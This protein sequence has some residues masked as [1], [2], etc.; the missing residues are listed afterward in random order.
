MGLE[1]HFRRVL[2]RRVY[3]VAAPNDIWHIDGYHRLIRCRIIIHEGIDGYSRLI[4]FLK[5]ATNNRADTMLHSFQGV[6]EF[7]LPCRVQMDK[8][9][10]NMLVAQYMLE[11][12]HRGVGQGSAI[13]GRSIHNQRIE[14]L[15]KDLFSGCISYFY[16]FFYFLEDCGLLQINDDLNIYA[17]Q[18][19]FLPI[20]QQQLDSFRLGWSHHSMRTENNRSPMQLWVSGLLEINCHLPAHPARTGTMTVSCLFLYYIEYYYG[21]AT[22]GKF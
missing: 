10:E 19:A 9:G 3:S 2:H 5:A 12:P 4:M 17:V 14:C 11:H 6:A 18:Y 22:V 13:V 7:G 16:F 8:G 1:H 21:L 15:W 20:I